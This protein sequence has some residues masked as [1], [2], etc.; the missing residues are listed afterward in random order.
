MNVFSSIKC[1]RIKTIQSLEDDDNPPKSNFK[2]HCSTFSQQFAPLKVIPEQKPLLFTQIQFP[3]SFQIFISFRDIF[4]ERYQ[5]E[6]QKERHSEAI[7]EI[8]QRFQVNLAAQRK[9]D[10]FGHLVSH[11]FTFLKHRSPS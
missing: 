11:T 5:I 6:V 7:F 2:Q 8:L 3:C 9:R 1:L 10:S 4:F